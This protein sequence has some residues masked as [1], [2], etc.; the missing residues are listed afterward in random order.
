MKFFLSRLV[1]TFG[2]IGYS[3]IA[4]GT[5]GSI[6]AT[7]IYWYFLPEGGWIWLAILISLSLIGVRTSQI[8]EQ[9]FQIKN[10]DVSAHDPS[11]I[12]FDEVAGVLFALFAIPKEFVLVLLALILFRVF[13]ILK[14]FPVKKFENLPHGWGIMMDDIV[15]GILANVIMRIVLFIK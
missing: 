13:D 11:I 8:T 10:N 15:S 5:L 14:P 2:G 12:V 3:P 1:S 7:I 4:P 6:A 9:E